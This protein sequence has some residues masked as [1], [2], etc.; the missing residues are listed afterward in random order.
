MFTPGSITSAGPVEIAPS[1]MSAT[2]SGGGKATEVTEASRSNQKVGKESGVDEA[3]TGRV[4]YGK[5]AEVKLRK[6]SQHIR[7]TAREF[8]IEIGI[9]STSMQ[10]CCSGILESPIQRLN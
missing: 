4:P 5:N 9:A 2:G 7:E 6:H 1:L 8:G 10:G 3:A